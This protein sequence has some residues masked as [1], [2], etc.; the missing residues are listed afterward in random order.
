MELSLDENQK[1]S[2]LVKFSEKDRNK[3]QVVKSV[4]KHVALMAVAITMLAPFFWMLSTSLKTGPGALAVPPQ[5]I[6]EPFVWGNF[7]EVFRR[8]PF[9][10][11]IW[12]STFH[13]VSVT[14]LE[15]AISLIVAY[16]FA[17]F[18]FKGKRILFMFLLMTIMLP[19]EITIVPGYIYWVRLS[20]ILNIQFIDTYW[21]LILPAIGGQAVH[22]FFMTQYF[23][24]ISKDFSEAAYINGASSWKILW[25]IYVPMSLPAI[26]TISISSFM[27]TW[28]AFLSPMIYLNSRDN[29][30]VQVGLQMFQGIDGAN[31]NW[32][33]VMAATTISIIPILVLFFA[34]QKYFIPSNKADGVK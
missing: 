4:V 14:F 23:R 10:R 7:L 22:I 21:P 15:V 13:S 6:P 1:I 28:N 32:A 27:G 30:N 31:I 25:K 20:E 2:Q 19:G 11:F 24:T 3:K 12:N 8:V 5:W 29:F 9:L 33:L 17:R 34:L 16:G 18:N 26:I